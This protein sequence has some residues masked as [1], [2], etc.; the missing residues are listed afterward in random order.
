MIEELGV[1]YLDGDEQVWEFV[2]NQAGDWSRVWEAEANKIRD[3]KAQC[4]EL[5]GPFPLSP[6]YPRI[7][8]RSI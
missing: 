4:W 8:P 3:L 7:C 6:K 5:E 1:L 2:T